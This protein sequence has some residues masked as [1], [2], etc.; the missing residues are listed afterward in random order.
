MIHHQV[1]R[2][3]RTTDIFI[4]EKTKTAFERMSFL[5]TERGF[6]ICAFFVSIEMKIGGKENAHCNWLDVSVNCKMRRI[7]YD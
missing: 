1:I 3:F 7:G 4:K 6:T 5:S 2:N